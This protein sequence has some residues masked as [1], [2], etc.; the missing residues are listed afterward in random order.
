MLQRR[1]LDHPA[2]EHLVGDGSQAADLQDHLL[3]GFAETADQIVA[4]FEV[5]R[6]VV[7]LEIAHKTHR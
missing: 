4:L 5:L 6:D 2:F 7:R 3:H 1:S